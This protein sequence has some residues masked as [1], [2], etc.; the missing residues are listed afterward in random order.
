MKGLP[1]KSVG[2]VL[3]DPPYSE[4]THAK[5]WIGAALT[6][7]GGKRMSTAHAGLGFSHITEGVARAFGAECQRL[8]QRWV[9]VFSDVEWHHFW[10]DWMPLPLVRVCIWDKVDSAP[11]FTGDRPAASAEVFL[12]FHADG[13][14]RW[15]GGGKRNV[16]RYEVNGERGPKP[17]PSTKPLALMEA[18]VSDFTDP[19]ELILD[20]FAGSGTTG[21][22]CK[23]LGR[24]FIGWEKDPV[25][26]AAA[27]KRIEAARQQG[28]FFARGPK[29]KQGRL[30]P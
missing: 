22:A 23:R 16:Y 24:G 30:L 3:T 1:D 25:F 8:A 17:H 14:K 2:V 12:L 7:A 20:P 27:V 15:N 11:Q 9:I 19:G 18:L 21:V 26:H 10:R 5:Q 13:R 28:E 29:P 4:H 6:V